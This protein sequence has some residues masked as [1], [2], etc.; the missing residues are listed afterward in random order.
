[1]G[2]VAWVLVSACLCGV[3]E[4]VRGVCGCVPAW[5]CESKCVLWSVRV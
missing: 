4:G 1:L 2:M 5:R 3:G